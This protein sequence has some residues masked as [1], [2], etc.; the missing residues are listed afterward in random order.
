MCRFVPF[1]K[2][3]VK[4]IIGHA[5]G[6]EFVAFLWRFRVVFY[7]KQPLTGHYLKA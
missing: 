5:G 7:E 1:L 3:T 6:S 2:N 4:T